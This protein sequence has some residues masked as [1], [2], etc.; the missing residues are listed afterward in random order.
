MSINAIVSSY[1]SVF[2][3]WKSAKFKRFLVVAPFSLAAHRADTAVN[4]KSLL[5]HCSSGRSALF[6]EYYFLRKWHCRHSPCRV[7]LTER[8][9]LKIGIITCEWLVEVHNSQRYFCCSVYESSASWCG[10]SFRQIKSCTLCWIRDG[11]SFHYS[12]FCL[13]VVLRSRCLLGNLRSQFQVSISHAYYITER[14]NLRIFWD[15][16]SLT[17]VAPG[18]LPVNPDERS[19]ISI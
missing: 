14:K 16:C 10:A 11:V 18:I 12:S 15:D 7:T 5:S 13:R 9:A 4:P 3:F 2:V 19:N 17:L 1:K 6:W 8:A